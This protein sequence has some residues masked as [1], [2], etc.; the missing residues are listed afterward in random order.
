MPQ[1]H[2]LEFAQTPDSLPLTFCENVY[3]V[4]RNQA[5]F[6][7]NIIIPDNSDWLIGDIVEASLARWLVL[8]PKYAEQI[9]AEFL[10]F[11]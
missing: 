4:N 5:M 9:E 10:R 2:V 11:S 8:V 3:P 6:G 1:L 7:K